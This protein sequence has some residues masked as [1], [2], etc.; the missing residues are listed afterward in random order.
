MV[1]ATNNGAEEKT[2]RKIKKGLQQMTIYLNLRKPP[3]K[4]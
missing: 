4:R 1:G 2:I 3:K